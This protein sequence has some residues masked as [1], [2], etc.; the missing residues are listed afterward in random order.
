MTG[1]PRRALRNSRRSTLVYEAAQEESQAPTIS[2][3]F[4]VSL[5]AKYAN[6]SSRREASFTVNITKNFAKA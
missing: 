4:Y 5:T 2:P 1:P 6:N 3:R